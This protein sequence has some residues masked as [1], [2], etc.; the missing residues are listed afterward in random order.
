MH[1]DAACLAPT[2]SGSRLARW[3]VY[4]AMEQAL[5]VRVIERTGHSGDD[6]HNV[7]GHSY[8][9]PRGEKP[10][11]VE[12]VDKVHRDPQPVVVFTAVVHAHDVRVPKV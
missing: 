10:S 11:R 4:V 9:I 5:F 3:P 2:R 12:A 7:G 6:A 1:T 8:R